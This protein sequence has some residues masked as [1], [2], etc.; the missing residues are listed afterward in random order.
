MTKPCV[1][2]ESPFSSTSPF[3]Q[4]RYILYL[5]ACIKHSLEKEEAPFASHGHYPHFLNDNDPEERALG[6]SCGRAW[7]LKADLVAFYLD[8][9]MSPGM[10]RMEIF[11]GSNNIPFEVRKIEWQG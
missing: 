2:V 4:A 11:C 3:Q 8:L 10:L 9:G 7:A 1:L 6:M 5:E